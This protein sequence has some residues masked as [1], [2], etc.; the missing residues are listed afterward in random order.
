[1]T[2]DHIEAWRDY[3]VKQ[4]HERYGV[5]NQEAQKTVECW[6]R[7]TGRPA[8][9]TEAFRQRQKTL[10]ARREAKWNRSARA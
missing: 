6:L 1:M 7:S 5:P 3:L 2:R 8:M 10:P 9:N 4:M